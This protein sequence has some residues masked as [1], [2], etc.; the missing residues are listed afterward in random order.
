MKNTLS[1]EQTKFNGKIISIVE[2][3]LRASVSED[4]DR[5]L[6]NRLYEEYCEAGK[7]TNI[8]AWLRPRLRE[9]FVSVEEQPDW[10]EGEGIWPFFRESQ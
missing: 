9:L 3:E 4:K 10:V 2:D 7:P 6:R 5:V 1:I 8:K